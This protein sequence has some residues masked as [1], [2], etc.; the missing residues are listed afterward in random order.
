MKRDVWCEPGNGPFGFARRE[1]RMLRNLRTPR[2]IQRLLNSLAYHEADTAWSPR[3]VLHEGQAHCLE[4]AL[5]AAAAL[6]AQGRPPLVVDMEAVRDVDHVIAVYRQGDRWGA[7][8]KSHFT[9]LRDRVP[10][11]RTLRELVL[12]YFEDYFNLLG[13]RTL[14]SYSRPVDLRRFDDRGWM[15]SPKPVWYVAE[16]LCRIPHVRLIRPADTKRLYRVDRLGVDAG[17]L[18]Y[19]RPRAGV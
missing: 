5:L 19:R 1:W 15:A 17:L 18:G 4:G 10:V 6:R 3:R 16:H 14:R 2:N 11:Y 12:S 9:G 13:E 7:L 8:A